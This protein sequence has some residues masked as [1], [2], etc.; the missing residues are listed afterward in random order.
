MKSKY[1]FLRSADVIT[2]YFVFFLTVVEILC[3]RHFPMWAVY[4]ISNLVF[5]IFI[6]VSSRYVAAHHEQHFS[7]VRLARDWYLVPA[8]LFIY[9]QA[10]SLAHP[11]HLRDYDNVLISI[12]RWLFGVNPTQWISQ[13]ALPWITEILQM[14]YSSYYLFFIVLFFELYRR[15]DMTAFYSGSMLVVYGFYLSYV[16]YMLVPA[17]GPRFTLHNF[18]MINNELPGVFLTPYLR[19]IINIG[20]GV[21]LDAAN[22]IAFIHRDAFPSGHTQLT[23]VAMYVAF[24]NHTQ[25]RW[26]LFVVGSLLIISTVYM[27]YHYVIDVAAGVAFFF[28]TIWSG[29]QIDRWWNQ[30]IKNV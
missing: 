21:P 13:F 4:T 19:E 18:L 2:I 6:Y 12:D 26:W 10:S 5:I 27:R 30:R 17:V 1:S 16:G 29:K 23:L 25:S 24:S 7:F 8:I 22:P 20:G 3:A 14:A 9:T 11:L 15:K 28:L